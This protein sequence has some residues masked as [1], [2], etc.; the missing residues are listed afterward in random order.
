MT[1]S[2]KRSGCCF[3][4]ASTCGSGRSLPIVTIA[5]ST[6]AAS[7]DATSSSGVKLLKMLSA[8]LK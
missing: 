8:R 5:F 2:A 1:E 4:N 7:I 3:G 6:P